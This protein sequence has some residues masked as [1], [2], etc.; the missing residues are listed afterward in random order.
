MAV[1]SALLVGTQLAS[2]RIAK[3]PKPPAAACSLGK[4]GKI[5]HVI[6]LQFDNVHFFRDNPNVPSDLE[7]MPNLLN[8]LKQNGTLLTNDHTILISHTG[9]GILASLTGLYPNRQGQNVSNAYGYFRPDGSVG[10]SSSFKYWTDSTDGGNPANNPPTPSA[11]PNYNMVNND[12]ASL[13]GTGA[14]RNAP[15]P[16][17]PFTRAGCDVGNVGTANAVLENNT[18]IATRSS[19]NTTLA[20]ASAAGATSITVASAANLSAGLTIILETT[21]VRAETATIQSIAGTTVNLT[22]P[23]TNAHLSGGAVTVYSQDPTGDMTRVFGANS[24]EWIEG[25]NSQIA[26]S[27]TAARNL[28]QT[29]F[30]GF[31]IHCAVGGGIC[32]DNA[33]NARPD[34]LP[35]EANGYT[36]F[37]GLFGAKYVNPA[38]TGGNACVKNTEGANIADQFGQCGFPGFDGVFPKN[39]LAEVAQM[40]EAGI[41]VTYGYISDAHDFHGTAGEQH[42]AYGPGEA[43]YVQQLK[44]YDKAFG[45][46][47]TR[48]NND[49]ITKDN[50]LFVVTVE[51]EDHPATSAPT[52]ANC[53]GVTVACTYQ[54]VTEVNGDLRKLVTTYN[55]SHGTNATLNFTVHS[56]L[57]P[58]VYITGNPGP[59]SSTARTLEQAFG[60]MQVTDPLNGVK[61]NLF[62][63]MAD[64]V[65]EKLLHMTTADPARTPTFTPFAQ[66]DFFLNASSTATT[67]TAC[68][69]NNLDNCVFLPSEAP[70]PNQTFAWNHGG[71]Q[72]EIRSTWI[73]YVGPGI[74][75]GKGVGNGPAPTA[76]DNDPGN[77]PWTDHT[78]IRPT[79]MALLGLKD[80]YVSDGRVVTEILKSDVTPNGLNGAK[81][82]ELGQLYKQI[83][84]SFGQFSMDTLAAS[85]AALASSSPGDGVYSDTE[86]QLQQL[87]A[88]RDQLAGEIRLGLWNAEFNGQKLD[89]KQVKDWIDRG[90]DLLDSAAAL[91]QS[92]SS[93]SPAKELGKIKHFVVIYEENHSF[94]N[95]YGGWEG[96]N[97][98]ANADTQHTQQINQAGNPFTCLKQDDV[99]LTSP[100]LPASCNDSSVGNTGGPFSSHFTNDPFQIED[101]IPPTAKTCPSPLVFGPANGILD[102]N[103]LAG[104]CTRDLVHRYYQ[105]QYQLNGGAQNRYVTGSDAMGLTMGHYDTTALPIYQYLHSKGAPDYAISDDFFQ[106]AFGGSFLNHQWLVAAATPVWNGALN[107]GS[108]NDL[109]SALDANG[110]PTSYGLYA[111]SPAGTAVKDQQLTQ[112]CS[113]AASRPPLQPAFVCGNY[114]VNTTQPLSQPYSPGTALNRRLPLQTGTTIGDELT[115]AGVDWAW[116]S[117]GWD[118]AAGV[119]T[120]PGWTNGTGPACSDPNTNTGALPPAPGHPTSTN[121]YPYCP[122]GLFQF[123]HQ[124]FNY[125]ANYAEGGP[126]R[127]H[128][129]DQMDFQALA[130]SSDNKTCNLK[131]VSFVKP[132]G[133]ENEHP[134]YA[135]TYQGNMSL[136]E[137]IQSI[138][139]SACAKD[140]MVIVTYDEFG[141]QWDHVSPPGQGNNNGPHDIWG[142]G[143]RI[144]A[145][146]I[147]PHLKGRFVVDSTEHD[148]TSIIATLEH[149]YGLSPLGSRD[150]AVPDMSSVFDAK[151]P[152][153]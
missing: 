100:P 55:A 15:A 76:A 35:D 23:L 127:S 84:A 63:A 65:E 152:K 53:D 121:T 32:N 97:G 73:G 153:K 6:Y 94:D 59:T 120:G 91:A 16:W 18:A 114:A 44:D 2:A 31:A 104:G 117:G 8:F 90:N 12:P 11:D 26:P 82:E 144:P 139:G 40:Q 136:T 128:L 135:S 124:A 92:F 85:T 17:V 47:F 147:A 30:V 3:P 137:L 140:T 77:Q 118:N 50:T 101:Y 95:L 64:P 24:P 43:G 7:Q 5:Q 71:I 68:A 14:N 61:D 88:D 87:G 105:E 56:D 143:T 49:G 58:N 81:T 107:D 149:R 70:P 69:D 122:D 75:K 115:A 1:G 66:G 27:G 96:V 42:H 38:I 106:S 54:H 86:A 45:Q 125:F 102:P 22:G 48:L 33:A 62:V 34:L 148:T 57:A 151:K 99:N 89:N 133:E 123:H 111:V 72:P 110:M 108:S 131:D 134:G 138:E 142:P 9:G 51:E 103:G 20:A 10:F 46:F 39:A 74:E 4:D 79:M 113:P 36:G 83:N 13:G 80:D 129:Q 132:I 28:A 37:K 29:D 145:L 126:G 119:T 93:E 109:H 150:A 78:D 130:T 25:R 146:T 19:G 112:S 141:G 98:L 52:P 41:P 60:D 116:Y 21:T 67:P